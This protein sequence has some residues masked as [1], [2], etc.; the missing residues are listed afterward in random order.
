MYTEEYFNTVTTKDT[1]MFRDYIS[2]LSAS[3][4]ALKEKKI[5]DIGCATGEFIENLYQTN[6]CYGTDYSEYAINTCKKKFPTIKEN[7][8]QAD[9]NT[10]K[11][12]VSE[13]FDV[14]TLFDVIEHLTNFNAL[15]EIVRNNLKENGLLVITTPNANSLTRFLQMKSFTGEVDP[16]HRMLFTSYTLDFFLKRMSLKKI[17]NFTP[18]VFYFK[19]DFITRHILF[20]GQIVAFYEKHS[21]KI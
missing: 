14:I 1:K 15:E 3:G 13:A 20:G 9:I 11:L 19:M 12:P 18:Y 5:L 10:E 7:F 4:M 2:F 8:F 17:E 6:L 21:K 16:T